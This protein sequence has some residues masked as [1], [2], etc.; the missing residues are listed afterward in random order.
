MSRG[1]KTKYTD[2]QKRQA[3]H[4]EAG[5]EQRGQNPR[6]AKRRAWATV[7]AMTGGG[8]ESGSG[9]GNR[10]KNAP[11]KKGGAVACGGAT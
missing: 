3:D 8:K 1:E 5:Y 7:I 11:A 6:E 9:R 2:K 4:I 10:I